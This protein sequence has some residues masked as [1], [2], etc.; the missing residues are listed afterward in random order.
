MLNERNYIID[1]AGIPME[2][3]LVP[4]VFVSSPVD[5]W[6]DQCQQFEILID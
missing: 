5:S 3:S 1:Q 4:I 6:L 2:A